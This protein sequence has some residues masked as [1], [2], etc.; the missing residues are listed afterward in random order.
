MNI[1]VMGASGRMG[2]EILQMSQQG[3]DQIKLYGVSRKGQ[4]EGY[5]EIFA[6]LASVDAHLIDLVIDFSLPEATDEVIQ[7]CREQRKPLVSGVTGL[8]NE[9][10]KKLKALAEEVPV[11]WSANMSLG[12]AVLTEALEVFKSL[13]GFDFQIEEIHHNKKKDN[14]SG[15]A[16]ALQLKLNEVSRKINPT[17]VGIRTGGVVG[18]HKVFAGSDEELIVFEHQALNRSVFARGA[19]KAARW[20]KAQ[21]PGFYS[22]KNVLFPRA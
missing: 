4:A 21:N 12:I 15:T 17:P 7:F 14:P 20:L 6:N 3:K 2:R 10:F 13:D 1:L 8:S 5:P 9:Q 11:L 16:L 19:L 22:L 18:V